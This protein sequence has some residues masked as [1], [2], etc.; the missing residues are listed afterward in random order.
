MKKILR[1]MARNPSGVKFADLCKVCDFYFGEGRQ[2]S[3]HIIYKTPW[4]GDHRINIQ[5]DNGKA[6]VYQVRQVL[7]AVEKLG[8]N[9][10]HERNA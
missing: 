3:S 1:K 2:E 7:K 4:L 6:K 10:S 9:D 8:V 5:D